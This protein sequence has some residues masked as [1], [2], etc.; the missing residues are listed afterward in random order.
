MT[1]GDIIAELARE[2]AVETLCRNI[3]GG[4]E[5]ASDLQDLSQMVYLILLD[6]DE[7]KLH[8]LYETGALPFFIVRIIIRQVRS[9]TSAYH[10]TIRA[11]RQK[12]QPI[13][14]EYDEE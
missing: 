10:L 7:E 4:S 8:D 6:Y 11:F 13:S 1:K 5:N 12:C 3:A 2:R 9:D 14:N